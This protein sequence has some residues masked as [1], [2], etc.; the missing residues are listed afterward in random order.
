MLFLRRVLPSA[1]ILISLIWWFGGGCSSEVT[2]KDGVASTMLNPDGS[3]CISHC[4]C[5][6]QH[7]QGLCVDGQCLS[8]QRGNCSK[9]G[10]LQDCRGLTKEH[11]YGEQVCFPSYLSSSLWGDCVC[12]SEIEKIATE[13]VKDAS[14]PDQPIP[15]EEKNFLRA[16]QSDADCTN[17]HFFVCMRPAR[18]SP[19]LC[20]PKCKDRNGCLTFCKTTGICRSLGVLCTVQGFC[21]WKDCKKDVECP[22]GTVCNRVPLNRTV[23]GLK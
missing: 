9:K 12:K 8:A 1:F 16:C 20:L 4:D 14:S 18:N 13:E 7:Y 2:C 23:C 3:K 5:S 22:E 17:K 19:L 10:Q 11:C 21:V 15:D 6:N